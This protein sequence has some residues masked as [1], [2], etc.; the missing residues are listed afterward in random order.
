MQSARNGP[1]SDWEDKWADR[2]DDEDD[3]Y[4]YD[5]WLA[6][7]EEWDEPEDCEWDTLAEWEGWK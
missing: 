6:H 4:D 1:C 5:E 3:L 7:Q 2:L